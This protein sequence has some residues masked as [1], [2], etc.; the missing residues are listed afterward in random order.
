MY[1][2]VFFEES[3]GCTKEADCTSFY[4]EGL[5]NPSAKVQ[6]AQATLSRQEIGLR[7]RAPAPKARASPPTPRNGTRQ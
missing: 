5:S 1:S 4:R 2:E 3:G 6:Q 7:T